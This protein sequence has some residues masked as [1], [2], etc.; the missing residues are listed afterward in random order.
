MEAEELL[1][2]GEGEDDLLPGVGELGSVG[3]GGPRVGRGRVGGGFEEEVG[4]GTVPGNDDEVVG[5][6]G[7]ERRR[8]RDESGQGE[9][10]VSGNQGGEV[11]AVGD[12]DG[13][14][15]DEIGGG[16][17]V[18]EFKAGKGGER[19]EGN[20]ERVGAGVGVDAGESELA[21]D[22]LPESE[23]LRERVG[24]VVHGDRVSPG[25][26]EFGDLREG[27]KVF[28][29]RVGKVHGVGVVHAE[30]APEA[31]LFAEDIINGIVAFPGETGGRA[32]GEVGEKILRG[33]FAIRPVVG[34]VLAGFA[35]R[36]P[37]VE[38][39]HPKR[40]IGVGRLLEEIGDAG[41]IHAVGIV[42]VQS[43]MRELGHDNGIIHERGH[44]IRVGRGK[45]GRDETDVAQAVSVEFH[46]EVM[47]H[48]DVLIGAA[49]A[50]A[51]GRAVR[52]VVRA[53]EIELQMFRVAG[54][55]KQRG[56]HFGPFIF[57][58]GS[59]TCAAHPIRAGALEIQDD[60]IGDAFLVEITDDAPQL[61]EGRRTVNRVVIIPVHDVG[62]VVVVR[63]LPIGV[64]EDDAEQGHIALV[65]ESVDD[66]LEVV[67]GPALIVEVDAEPF[68]DLVGLGTVN[69]DR[70]RGRR[71]GQNQPG[72]KPQQP[73]T[74]PKGSHQTK[75]IPVSGFSAFDTL[76]PRN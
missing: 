12:G 35:F 32:V 21:G 40:E 76:K 26:D 9:D 24:V 68:D 46:G 41:G 57:V 38:L 1:T 31:P 51:L 63:A 58:T 18:I 75:P 19:R 60:A 53:D 13:G 66:R 39:R 73:Q 65:H 30:Q 43:E 52:F 47:Q 34:A 42:T 69:Q 59:E 55:V 6:D 71:I 64:V 10:A 37:D 44:K 3:D 14:E 45:I 56:D 70:L 25:W 49:D 23:Q 16:V 2:G 67:V 4:D 72:A 17:G 29:R 28:S 50:D 48:R 5:Q 15:V 61:L 22:R 33:A 74:F 7:L 27:V 54:V 36:A 8:R 62:V 11:G 20:G